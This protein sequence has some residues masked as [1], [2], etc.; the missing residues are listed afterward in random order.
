VTF[1]ACETMIWQCST[2]DHEGLFQGNFAN[3]NTYGWTDL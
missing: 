1:L 2:E 3:D